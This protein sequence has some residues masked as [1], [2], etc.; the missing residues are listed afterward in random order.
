[1]ASVMLP[2]ENSKPVLK[3]VHRTSAAL[4]RMVALRRLHMIVRVLV[5][6]AVGD[7]PAA[8]RGSAGYAPEDERHL[9]GLRVHVI[10]FYK[11]FKKLGLT[12]LQ[13]RSRGNLYSACTASA[14]EV[15]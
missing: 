4:T 11:N 7:R 3:T 13:D 9:Q 5:A 2:G 1:M 6:A 10:I 12:L 8:R 14:I 15:A